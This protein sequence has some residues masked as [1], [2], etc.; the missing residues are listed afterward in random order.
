[1]CTRCR[2][3][4]LGIAPRRVCLDNSWTLAR[5][6]DPVDLI[7]V[8]ASWIS[9]GL[10]LAMGVSFVFGS[11]SGLGSG[12][13]LFLELSLL[14]AGAATLCCSSFEHSTAKAQR[15]LDVFDRIRPVQIAL[16]LAVVV[17]RPSSKVVIVQLE[18]LVKPY[19]RQLP[20]IVYKAIRS[21]TRT[22]IGRAALSTVALGQGGLAAVA[23]RKAWARF[24]QWDYARRRFLGPTVAASV[25]EPLSGGKD[26]KEEVK[27]YDVL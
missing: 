8:L 12:L 18:Q 16:L 25:P 5:F 19:R 6:G 21:V 23:L 26:E 17:F 2:Q 14:F 9:A 22:S 20:R 3:H 10:T 1:M 4:A 24:G 27:G 7:L 15:A 13:A 11:T